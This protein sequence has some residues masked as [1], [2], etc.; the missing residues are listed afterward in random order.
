MGPPPPRSQQALRTD[1]DEGEGDVST[2]P[3]TAPPS[4]VAPPTRPTASTSTSNH[5]NANE[6]LDRNPS[7]IPV[8]HTDSTLEREKGEMPPP[9]STTRP[10]PD[11][12]TT[13]LPKRRKS[14]HE[15]A[16]VAAPPPP[17]D[18]EEEGQEEELTQ[19][20]KNAMYGKRYQAMM[21]TLDYAI[22]SS[23]HRMT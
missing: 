23:S 9:T 8:V 18:P 16:T 22:K 4:Q 14:R 10:A 17:E 15:P 7:P 11:A 20:E 3:R 5:T 12:F 13:P 21:D 1:E 19:F 2:T 6:D